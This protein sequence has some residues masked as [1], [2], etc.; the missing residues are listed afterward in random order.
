ME[1]WEIMRWVFG[2]FAAVIAWL[3]INN[4]QQDKK[5][6]SIE[7]TLE[8]VEKKVDR[9]SDQLTIF[10]KNEIDTLKELM[11]RTK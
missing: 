9:V 6:I 8:A 10:L 3:V 2:G 7:K 11:S 4:L 5:L 1:N